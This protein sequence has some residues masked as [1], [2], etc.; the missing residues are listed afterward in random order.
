MTA[1]GIGAPVRRK[2]DFRFITGQGQYTDDVTRPGETRAVFVRSPHAHA[3]IKSIDVSAARKMPGVIDVL[4]GA[5]LATDKIGNLICGWMI[6]SK[7]GS[8]MKMAAH[9]ALAATKVNC[10]GDAVAVV[11]AE[12]IAQGKDAAEKVKVDYEV[13]PAVVDPAKAQAKGA[14]QI[15][16]DIENNT[17]YQWHLGEKKDVFRGPGKD[18]GADQ[19]LRGQRRGQPDCPP[20]SRAGDRAKGDGQ[21]NEKLG[22]LFQVGKVLVVPGS[23]GVRCLY[24]QEQSASNSIMR[25][26]DMYHRNRG[27]QHR[28][29]QLVDI[30]PWKMHSCNSANGLVLSVEY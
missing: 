21:E 20:D 16:P 17:I 13:L 27:D 26:Q 10:V 1:T 11:I 15:H 14:P 30:P 22:V 6:H 23:I 25:H 18:K 8:P 3:K 24:S 5:Q 19:D 4:T 29:G 12:T 7:D 2:E 9:P 28:R